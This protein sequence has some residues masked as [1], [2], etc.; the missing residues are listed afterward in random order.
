MLFRRVIQQGMDVPLDMTL[1]DGDVLARSR[2][3]WWADVV[4]DD[5]P[6]RVAGHGPCA[7]RLSV[8]GELFLELV[9]LELE[10]LPRLLEFL[11]PRLYLRHT[12]LERVLQVE[13]GG[14]CMVSR[15]IPNI[16]RRS[17]LVIRAVLDIPFRGLFAV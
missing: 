17:D 16:S 6:V 3:T 15:F 12:E 11:L 9:T 13:L 2:E 7:R 5:P 10:R 14:R 4:F 8:A 1:L